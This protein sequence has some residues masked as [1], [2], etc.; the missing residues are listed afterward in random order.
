LCW[1]VARPI[2]FTN[3]PLNVKRPWAIYHA[4]SFDKNSNVLSNLL[5]DKTRDIVDLNNVNSSVDNNI[6]YIF[7]GIDSYVKFPPYSIN[8]NFTICSVT[9]YNTNN[10]CNKILTSFW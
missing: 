4:A 10:N 5:G 8:S 6:A 7:G 3:T 9:R 2:P 1:K